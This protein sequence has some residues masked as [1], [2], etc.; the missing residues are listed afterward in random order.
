MTS[1]CLGRTFSR[2][3]GLRWLLIESSCVAQASSYVAQASSLQ[4]RVLVPLMMLRSA[5][6]ALAARA[7]VA[8]AIL[9]GSSIHAAGALSDLSSDNAGRRLQDTPA[10]AACAADINLVSCTLLHKL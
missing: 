5:L 9:E 10:T 8:I 3:P 2:G 7:S 6:L 4:R 1:P